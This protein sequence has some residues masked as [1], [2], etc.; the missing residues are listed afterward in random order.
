[1]NE[2]VIL[3]A[4]RSPFGKRG[5]AYREIQPVRLLS[6][7]LTGLVAR[8]GLEPEKVEDVLTGVVTQVNEQGANIGRL[9]VLDAPGLC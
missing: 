5:G 2:P 4:V 9:A 3:E 6:G 8:A 7:V 1:M